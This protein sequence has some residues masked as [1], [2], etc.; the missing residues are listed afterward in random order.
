MKHLKSTPGSAQAK[1]KLSMGFIASGREALLAGKPPS[2]NHK[3]SAT[4][5]AHQSPVDR[6]SKAAQYQDCLS[7][8]QMQS[9][10]FM[11]YPPTTPSSYWITLSGTVS[12][13][14]LEPT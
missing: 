11:Y 13:T 2:Y 5:T 4:V 10:I 3:G 8:G 1:A 6:P 9:L 7:H 14:A 12:H